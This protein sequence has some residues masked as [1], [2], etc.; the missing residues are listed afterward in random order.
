VYAALYGERP[1]EPLE[2]PSRITETL[3]RL[4]TPRA[5]IVP[6]WLQRILTRGLAA[7]RRDRWP[8]IGALTAAIERR[9]GYRRR[10]LV[11]TAIS[12]MAVAA[13]GMVMIVRATPGPP[14]PPDGSPVLIGREGKDSPP[15]APAV[16]AELSPAL[17]PLA[18]WL[19]DWDT[20]DG[21]GSEHW[22]A[23]AG[24]IYGVALY[25][26]TFEVLVIDD[27]D[28]SGRY[29]GAPRFF[30]MPNGAR[31]VEF[32]R[33]TI[34]DGAATFANDEHD[35]P[36]TITY[37]LAADRAGLATRL[38]GGGTLS[39][40]RFK[41]GTRSP[42]PDLE[43]ADLAFVAATVQRGVDGWV[44]AFDPKG[45]MIRNARRVEYAAIAKFMT[46]ML[47]SGRL[48]WAPIAS[49]QSGELGFTVGKGSFTGARPENGWRNTYVTI[50]RRQPDGAWK[51]LFDTGRVVQD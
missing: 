17:A 26:D 30:V 10:A 28:D 16:S 31:S 48:D 36:T 25:G 37:E 33:S 40:F 19:G 45:G 50:W 27:G 23:A 43:A 49:G 6:R 39:S 46:P 2:G 7:D 22:I 11:M 14:E 34:G 1:F 15:P 32:P 38:G 18:W 24:A 42:A 3:G 20:S 5:G 8:T 9:L 13:T 51:V 21:T 41:R 35:F 29:Y 12:V 47:S 44:A 4:R